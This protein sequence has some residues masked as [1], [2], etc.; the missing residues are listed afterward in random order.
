MGMTVFVIVVVMVVG[1]V[2]F[3]EADTIA[4][5]DTGEL[6]GWFDIAE[7]KPLALP[8]FDARCRLTL[9]QDLPTDFS[10]TLPDEMSR[11]I[12]LQL[13]LDQPHLAN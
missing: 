10:T 6:S 4:D 8:A 3:P 2:W 13:Y 9:W 11:L 1:V 7:D 5:V 12:R